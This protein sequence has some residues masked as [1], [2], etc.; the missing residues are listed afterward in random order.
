MGLARPNK[1]LGLFDYPIHEY[2]D[3]DLAPWVSASHFEIK[4]V[5]HRA[6]IYLINATGGLATLE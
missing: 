5:R 3:C 1:A 4:H 6:V 2:W